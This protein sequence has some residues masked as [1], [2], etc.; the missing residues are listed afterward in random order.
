MDQYERRKI[1]DEVSNRR[2][3]VLSAEEKYPVIMLR[4]MV[5]FPNSHVNFDVSR[6][7]SVKALQIAQK[8]GGKVVL[9]SQKNP[10]I[11]VP[12]EDDLYRMG[13]LCTIESISTETE[14]SMRVLVKGEV[15]KRIDEFV[16][17]RGFVE[18]YVSDVTETVEDEQLEES[19]LRIIMRMMMEYVKLMPQ[20][21]QEIFLKISDTKNSGD[22][23]DNVASN[24][25]ARFTD[26]QELL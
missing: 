8:N 25:V 14:N 6:K 10:D 12:N 3:I 15:R 18:A 26:A 7:P 20:M 1:L 17:R 5:V 13:T 2:E 9:V 19:C 11:E 22:F 23:A 16:F 21:P 24:I 4:G